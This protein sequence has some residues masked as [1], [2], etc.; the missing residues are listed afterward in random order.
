VTPDQFPLYRYRASLVKITDGDTA[1]L[2]IDLGF[3]VAIEQ[4]VRI[5]GF[6]AAETHGPHPDLARRAADALAHLL[7]GSPLYVETL[8][9]GQSFARYLGRVL[10]PHPDTAELVDVADAMKAAGFDVERGQ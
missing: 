9:D 10:V 5:V 4:P 6:N 8:K 3:G 1:R 7:A 2:K